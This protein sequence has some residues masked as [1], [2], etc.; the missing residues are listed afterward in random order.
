MVSLCSLRSN[1]LGLE[2]WGVAAEEGTEG[3]EE[4]EEDEEIEDEDDCPSYC[5]IRRRD[6]IWKV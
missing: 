2:C 4:D 1:K 6:W 3:K 5:W